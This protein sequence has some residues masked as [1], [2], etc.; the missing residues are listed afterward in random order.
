MD[1][2]KIVRFI[3]EHGAIIGNRAGFDKLKD[4]PHSRWIAKAVFSKEDWQIT[5]HRG[6]YKS[7]AVDMVGAGLRMIL[8]PNQNG[9]IFRKDDRKV[10]EVIRGISK[11]LKSEIAHWI[12]M[13]I[14]GVDYSIDIDNTDEIQISYYCRSGGAIQ[15][16]G[17][18]FRSAITSAHADW[19]LTDDISD[20]SDYESPVEKEKTKL[21]FLELKNIINKGGVMGH[22]NTPWA[23]DDVRILM[24]EPEILDCYSSGLLSEEEIAQKKQE[25]STRPDLFA[26]N[27]ELRFIPSG[28]QLFDK[29]V[30]TDDNSLILDGVAHIDCAYGGG[31]TTAL[32]ILNKRPDDTI[33]GFGAVW[34]RSI[35]QCTSEIVQLLSKYRVKDILI[36]NNADKGYVARD[37]NELGFSVMPYH[38]KQN[39]DAKITTHGVVGWRKTKWIPA[40]DK[41]YLAQIESYQK[42]VG[43]DDCADSFASLCRYLGVITV[44]FDSKPVNNGL[45]VGNLLNKAKNQSGVI[46]F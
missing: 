45:T 16:V 32:T 2:E 23:I 39:K 7:T 41:V 40:T 29:A 5:A 31:D 3:K 15:V 42:G 14:W 21:N 36:E 10:K 26:M 25:F 22:T 37:F 34:R 18:G 13:Q 44:E 24:P 4:D 8:Y 46:R 27:Y 11:F 20:L 33:Y 35:M 19:I 6:S 12:G 43:N 30:M 28:M 38:E 17:R 1:R 9:I